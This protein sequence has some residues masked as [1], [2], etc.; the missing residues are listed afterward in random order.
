MTS[1][2]GIRFCKTCRTL[3]I[4][5]IAVHN[6]AKCPYVR[7]PYGNRKLCFVILQ[8]ARVQE[9]ELCFEISHHTRKTPPPTPQAI[10]ASINYC[11]PVMPCYESIASHEGRTWKPV[12]TSSHFR[13]YPLNC[14][15]TFIHLSSSNMPSGNACFSSIYA[16]KSL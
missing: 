6:F 2:A 11:H 14:L 1:S 15:Y 3:I 8:T 5:E 7:G 10:L 12:L 4:R 9:V 16:P 13:T